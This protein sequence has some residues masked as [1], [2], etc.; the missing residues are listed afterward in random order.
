MKS[1]PKRRYSR[2]CIDIG[3]FHKTYSDL[4]AE[5]IPMRVG[6]LDYRG[7][8][9]PVFTLDDGQPFYESGFVQVNWRRGSLL[10]I[11]IESEWYTK[12]IHDWPRIKS[13]IQIFF[14][15]KNTI[16]YSFQFQS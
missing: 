11:P 9:I 5:S 6:L 8:S 2:F 13:R 12:D 15:F 4:K 7:R 10:N 3:A 1:R 14:E 16:L